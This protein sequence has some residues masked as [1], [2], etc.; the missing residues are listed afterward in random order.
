M[1]MVQHF[2]CRYFEE[3]KLKRDVSEITGNV[4]EVTHEMFANW[5][6]TLANWKLANRIVGEKIAI[7]WL[8]DSTAIHLIHVLSKFNES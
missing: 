7:Q 4:I 2:I 1:F 3:K 8:S 5:P 6:K